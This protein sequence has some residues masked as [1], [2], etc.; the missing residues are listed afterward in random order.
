MDALEISQ[1]AVEQFRAQ[2]VNPEHEGLSEAQIR[3][4]ILNWWAIGTP[5]SLDQQR[6]AGKFQRYG[7]EDCEHRKAAGWVI[8]RVQNTIVTVHFKTRTER[9]RDQRRRRSAR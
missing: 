7:L 1:H 6:W 8:T 2:T 5:Q 9:R 3:R 4:R